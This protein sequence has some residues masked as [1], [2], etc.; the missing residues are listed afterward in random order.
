MG[1]TVEK[2]YSII[3]LLITVGLCTLIAFVLGYMQEQEIFAKGHRFTP[4]IVPAGVGLAMVLGNSRKLSKLAILFLPI[5]FALS[6]VVAFAGVI[7]AG[8]AELKQGDSNIIDLVVNQVPFFFA[9]YVLYKSYTMMAGKQSFIIFALHAVLTIML[10]FLIFR[11][12]NEYG[13]T[14]LQ[15]AY[16]GATAALF[17]LLHFGK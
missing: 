6:I 3:N 10:S 16:Y 14:L 13:L 2:K 4:F 1:T 11:Q 17:S 12:I 7:F 5:V 15:T 8:G 9:S